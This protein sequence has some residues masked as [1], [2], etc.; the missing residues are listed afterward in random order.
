SPARP[1]TS[2]VGRSCNTVGGLRPTPPPGPLPEAERGCLAGLPLSASGRGPGGGVRS[3]SSGRNGDEPDEQRQLQ[4][5][6][7]DRP[8]QEHARL[9]PGR[10]V[11]D[12]DP[13]G[14]LRGV[15]SGDRRPPGRLADLLGAVPQGA[16]VGHAP[17]AG[18][19]RH[20][21][22]G[23]R[24]RPGRA[25]DQHRDAAGRPGRPAGRDAARRAE[26]PRRR[27]GGGQRGEPRMTAPETTTPAPERRAATYA[28]VCA[29]LL[30]ISENARTF[31]RLV[32]TD[33]RIA[34]TPRQVIWTLNK[35]K[36]YRYVPVVP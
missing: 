28:D 23:R 32:T 36:L 11:E 3:S 9:R 2:T 8:A 20:A 7:P 13:A 25:P 12:N 19:P 1:S 14:Q 6:R 35:A 17:G 29:E 30:R 27:E 31:N 4:P 10:L 34:Q 21:H 15:R 26:G 22:P 16:G 18:R 33:A 5:L 24:G